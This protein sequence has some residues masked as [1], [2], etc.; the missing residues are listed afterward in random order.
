MNIKKIN[1]IVTGSVIFVLLLLA[2][3]AFSLSFDVLQNE[4]IKY[5]VNP[6]LAWVFAIIIDIGIIG[7]SLFVIWASLNKA[8]NLVRLGYGVIIGVTTLSVYLNMSHAKMF[9][10]TGSP[11]SPMDF[12]GILPV[13]YMI[14]PPLLL[15]TMTYLVENMLERVIKDVDATDMLQVKLSDLQSIISVLQDTLKSEQAKLR[16]SEVARKQLT[17]DFDKVA[18][19]LPLLPYVRAEVFLFAKVAASKITIEEAYR[20]QELYKRLDQFK[21]LGSKIVIGMGD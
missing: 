13:V 10:Q 16:E 20:E 19:I 11:Q 9:G 6:E 4:A 7:C 5:G 21:A 14:A 12:L 17:V 18:D 3:G 8:R 15:A 2:A 1:N